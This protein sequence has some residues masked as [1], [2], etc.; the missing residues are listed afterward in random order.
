MFFGCF[1]CGD[2]DTFADAKFKAADTD[3]ELKASFDRACFNSGN[4]SKSGPDFIS[5]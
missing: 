1:Q 3:A 5:G 4:G 2:V